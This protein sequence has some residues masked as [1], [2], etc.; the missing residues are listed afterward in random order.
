L[1]IPAFLNLADGAVLFLTVLR[2]T[3]KTM[4]VF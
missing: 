2:L 1:T 3:L 4:G